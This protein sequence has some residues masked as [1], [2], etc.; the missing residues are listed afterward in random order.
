M[1][2]TSIPASVPLAIAQ[3]MVEGFN[4]HYRLFRET[5]SRAK[6]RFEQAKWAD[7]QLAV[8]ER[9][10]YYDE[11]VAECVERLCKE[12][13]AESLGDAEW[14]QAKFYYIGLL[15]DH[16]QPE[17]AET[18]FNS[19]TTKILHYTYFH[20][21]FIFFRPAVST[22]FI[23]SD[24]PTYRCYYPKTGGGLR[25]CIRRLFLDIGWTLPFADLDRDVDYVMRTLRAHLGGEWPE[26]EPNCQIKVLNSPFY[27]NKGAY[28]IGTAVNGN[29]DWPFAVPVV[30][31][32]DDKLLLDTV[33][34][35]RGLISLLFSLSRAYF[36]VDMEV[37][38]DYVQFLRAIMPNKPRSE[39][40]TMLGLGKQGKNMFYR[41]LWHHLRHS[42]D[43]F[44][45]APGIRGMVMHVFMLPSYPYVF[46]IIMDKFGSSKDTTR[47]QVKRKFLIVKQVDRVGRMADTL[48][49]AELAL[50]RTRFSPELLEQLFERAPSIVRYEG[51]N[52][53]IDHCYIERR[54]TPLNIYL[55]TGDDDMIDHAVHEYGNAIREL[56][57]ANIFPGDLLWKNFGV[58]RYGRVVFYD[59]DEIEYLTDCNFR[60]IPPAPHPDMELSGEVWYSVARND[61]FPEEFA[62][63]LLGKPKVRAAF[64]KYHRDLLDVSFWQKTQEAIRRGEFED[65]FPYPESI[66][67][68]R[69][70]RTQSAA[71]EAL[72]V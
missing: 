47:E 59:Y 4:K 3:A 52:V 16:K 11:R 70:F 2:K 23:E 1:S 61:I 25:Q 21:Q 62:S 20:N 29:D 53:I 46:K 38:S 68:C 31:D 55:D 56:A 34:L 44:V 17:L 72:T 67:F 57:R 27:R 8:K 54:M 37:P 58:T 14:Q 36:M 42:D 71:K 33:L 19:V 24:P 63:F 66:R 69:T 22:E 35:D 60:R 64:L 10:R 39:L 30:H 50:P 26:I 5:A 13:N 48:E 9:I 32:P 41:D 7:V 43:Q 45:E 15:V 6:A 49:F 18:F 12:H 51:S 28:V 40:Y 65:F